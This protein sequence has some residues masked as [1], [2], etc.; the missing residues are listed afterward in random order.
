MDI[1][2]WN[3]NGL[4][5][6]GLD[7]RTE[8]ALQ[9]ILL[10][11]RIELVASGQLPRNPPDVVVLQEVTRRTFHAHLKH[12]LRAAGF[13]VRPASVPDRNY[14]ELVAVRPPWT[15]VDYVQEPLVRTRFGRWLHRACVEGPDGEVT[16]LTAHF[17]SGPEEASSRARLAQLRDVTSLMERSAIFAGDTNLREAEWSG[18][19]DGN[20]PGRAGHLPVKDAWVET[21]RP[22]NHRF[23]WIAKDR[24]ARFDRV[25]YSPDLAA[26]TFETI[27]VHPV[28][29]L[30]ELPSDH[31]GL[32]ACIR[33]SS[34]R[35]AP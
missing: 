20:A 33:P 3:L 35:L 16:I 11:H 5:E 8:A 12:H 9:D 32:R 25:F 17:D 7:L 14:F 6:G 13:E 23:T 30:G 27:G 22:A 2:T 4:D 1:V 10:G 28:T 15:V 24:K 21:G 29:E 34:F 19:V 31:L 18:L 26:E